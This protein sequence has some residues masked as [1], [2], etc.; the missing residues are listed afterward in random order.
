MPQEPIA[1]ILSLPVTPFG[2]Y[3]ALSAV[4]CL[5]FCFIRAKDYQIRETAKLGFLIA[6]ICCGV[7]CGHLLYGLST[8]A[9]EHEAYEGNMLNILNPASGGFMIIGA[10]IGIYLL[11]LAAAK[12]THCSRRELLELIVPCLVLLLVF[13]RLGEPLD[14]QGKGPEAYTSTRI[15]TYSPEAEYPDDRYYSAFFFEAA[16]ALVILSLY[17]LIERK[18]PVAPSFLIILYLAGQTFFE[19]FRQDAYT[20][21]TSLIT[22][23]RLNELYAVI[24]LF[25]YQV[26]GI[27]Q[28]IKERRTKR[29]ILNSLL[30]CAG[31]G[32][33]IW[34]QFLFDK[35]IHFGDNIIYLDNWCVYLILLVSSIGIGTSTM[36]QCSR[37]IFPQN[38]DL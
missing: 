19:L 35:P 32:I 1:T 27:T 28:N 26:K 7:F 18:R 2:A 10:G 12:I 24:L 20:H 29:V 25:L 3:C 5:L 11:S 21:Y 36:L 8:L 33:N 31:I 6:A 9:V 16:Y 15:I 30:F 13:I 14:G 23:I 4:V 38:S 22:F 37:S 17:L 34:A